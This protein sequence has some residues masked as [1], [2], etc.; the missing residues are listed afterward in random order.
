MY[1][2]IV[3]LGGEPTR[4]AKRRMQSFISSVGLSP[5]GYVVNLR[6]GDE[7][8]IEGRRLVYGVRGLTPCK[9]DLLYTF[10]CTHLVV[11]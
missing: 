6:N 8:V 11:F 5:G 4:C 10:S 9:R 3:S 7:R 1:K 2:P